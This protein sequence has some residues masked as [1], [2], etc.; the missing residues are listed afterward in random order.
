MHYHLLPGGAGVLDADRIL[1]PSQRLD[2]PGAALLLEGRIAAIGEREAVE[3]RL[4]ELRLPPER[5]R[6][7]Q[8]AERE[9]LAPGFVDLHAHLREPG[10]E[11]KETIASGAAAGAHGGFTTL[12]CMPNTQPVLDSRAALE[13]VRSAGRDVL[14]RV[15]PIAAITKGESGLELSEMAE[16]VEAG[17]GAL[18]DDRRPGPSSRP[19]RLGAPHPPPLGVPGGWDR[20]EYEAV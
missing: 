16:L 4:A 15:R 13:Y 6:T 18:S 2:G 7:V 17:A 10:F 9:I 5:L 1:D 12:C 20:H 3:R 19:M 11:A 8:L 14:A